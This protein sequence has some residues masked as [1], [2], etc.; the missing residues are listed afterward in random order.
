MRAVFFDLDGTLVRDGAGEAVRRTADP[1]ARRHGLAASEI[2]AA[3]ALVWPDCWSAQGERW[4]RGELADDAL[5]REMWRLT[6]QRFGRVD[7]PLLDEAVAL[8]V[9][10][11]QQTFS[12]FAETLEVLD[13]LRAA[14]V[15]LGVIT[16]GPA[17]FQ[18]AKLVAA[19]IDVLF[20]V[21]VAS[22]DFGVLKP[23]AAI[24]RHALAALDV[25]AED[26][27]HVGDSFPADVVGAA[28]A[29][30]TAIWVNRDAAVAPRADL[31]HLDAR[32]LRAVLTIAGR[33][34]GI[35]AR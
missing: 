18:R 17:E 15:P 33:G 23:D 27:V 20:D 13:A 34:D 10:A 1:L 7:R 29:G 4:M 16:N 2:L 35:R 22:G 5:P 12:L 28:D 19:G 6:L 9:Q 11:E 30:M 26:A 24:F 3:N 31:A 8:H 21:V 25:R 14:R 32:S